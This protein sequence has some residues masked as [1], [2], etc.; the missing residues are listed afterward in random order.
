MKK[1]ALKTELK[2]AQA[3]MERLLSQRDALD[4]RI[5]KQREAIAG[6]TLVAG[7]W[8]AVA[9]LIGQAKKATL[10]GLNQ[11]LGL[12]ASCLEV[13]RASDGPLT[14]IE[15]LEGIKNLGRT[16]TV[17]SVHKTL[18]RLAENGEAEERPRDGRKA[19]T[20]AGT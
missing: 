12:K 18:S 15:V 7:G 19:Y 4:K 13:L 3:K 5:A 9:A 11:D 6:F 10:A 20:L 17:A 8:D 2:Q 1:R 16:S 14:P